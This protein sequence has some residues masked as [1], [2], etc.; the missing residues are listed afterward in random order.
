MQLLVSSPWFGPEISTTIVDLSPANVDFNFGCLCPDNPL[1]SGILK[2]EQAYQFEAKVTII[3]SF[4]I[5]ESIYIK[6]ISTKIH[7]LLSFTNYILLTI[8]LSKKVDRWIQ[9]GSHKEPRKHVQLS[10]KLHWLHWVVPRVAR[11]Q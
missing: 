10:N 8:L 11:N 6:T 7:H 3:Y 2:F 4:T 9:S 5:I 1:R